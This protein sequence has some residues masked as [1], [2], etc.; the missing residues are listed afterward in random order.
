[1]EIAGYFFDKTRLSEDLSGIE[2]FGM[3]ETA[4]TKDM[5]I[6]RYLLIYTKKQWRISVMAKAIKRLLTLSRF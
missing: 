5:I 2:P 4:T 6:L 1:M 3:D